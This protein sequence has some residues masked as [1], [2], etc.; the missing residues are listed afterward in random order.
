MDTLPATSCEQH[1]H[2]QR[3]LHPSLAPPGESGFPCGLLLRPTPPRGPPPGPNSAPCLAWGGAPWDPFPLAVRAEPLS[4]AGGAGKLRP[5]PE[6][7]RSLPVCCPGTQA[8]RTQT[9]R[10]GGGSPA[11]GAPNPHPES[12]G[13]AGGRCGLRG[14]PVQHQRLIGHQE[15]WNVVKTPHYNFFR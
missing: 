5:P 7:H 11:Q 12:P 14:H 2:H 13:G 1:V 3:R 10:A 6:M 8:G 9:P 4:S 15:P